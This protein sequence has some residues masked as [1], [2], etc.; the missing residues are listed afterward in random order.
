M[1]SI[2]IGLAG[3]A[4]LVPAAAQAQAQPQ[5]QP[6]DKPPPA[7]VCAQT[8]AALPAEAPETA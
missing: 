8:D 6:E 4:A 7:S 3:V 5:H 1:R 2:L